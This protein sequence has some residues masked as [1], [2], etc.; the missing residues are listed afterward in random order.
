MAAAALRPELLLSFVN[1]FQECLVHSIS[2]SAIP[3]LAGIDRLQQ[4]VG[5]HPH[6]CSVAAASV[7]SLTLQHNI[8]VVSLTMASIA[9]NTCSINLQ[10]Q[11][12]RR[13]EP[14]TCNCFS[15]VC[16]LLKETS[17]VLSVMYRRALPT[18]HLGLS[19]SAMHRLIAAALFTLN[20]SI[21]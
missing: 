16:A 18:S 17:T 5:Q 12:Y 4:G 11:S 21:V 10:H 6:W 19:P 13:Q 2:P 1:G 3:S 20:F 7:N 15:N 9:W 14:A 8:C